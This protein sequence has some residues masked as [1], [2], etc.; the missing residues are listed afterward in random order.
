VT[1]AE[2]TILW[3]MA[4]SPDPSTPLWF[5]CIGLVLMFLWIAIR[6]YDGKFFS[7]SK[8]D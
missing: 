2:R 7:S 5:R 3:V 1:E 8:V 6:I 4:L